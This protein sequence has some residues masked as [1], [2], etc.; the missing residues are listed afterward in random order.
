MVK[1]A[2]FYT[3]KNHS[4]SQ[5]KKRGFSLIELSVAIAVLGLIIYT[6]LAI[7]A[8]RSKIDKI[9]VTERKMDEIEKAIHLYFLTNTD[10][11]C[12]ADGT[13]AL[14][15]AAFA[16]ENCAMDNY[17]LS[18]DGIVSGVVPTRALNLPDDYMFDGWGRRF[19]YFVTTAATG[20]AIANGNMTINDRAIAPNPANTIT[21]EAVYVLISYGENGWGAWNRNGGGARKYDTAINA[22]EIENAHVASDGSNATGGDVPNEIFIDDLINDETALGDANEYFD[23]IV[24]WKTKGMIDYDTDRLP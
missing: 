15:V 4:K 16:I 11:P 18:A 13:V 21:A 9:A 22:H 6:T 14:D 17:E 5:H 8:E 3:M 24:R 12:A 1:L 7:F 23:D 19:S 20:G 2:K 10:L